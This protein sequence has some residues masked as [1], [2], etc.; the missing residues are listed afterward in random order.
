MIVPAASDDDI[1]AVPG[2]TSKE[3]EYYELN[4]SNYK[5]K[6]YSHYEDSDQAHV[7]STVSQCTDFSGSGG[8]VSNINGII[9]L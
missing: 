1:M 4:D 9:I 8:A 7:H 5:V 3:P 6:L 2:K